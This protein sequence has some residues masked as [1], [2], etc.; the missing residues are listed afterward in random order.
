MHN[1]IYEVM[2]TL[3]P[4]QEEDKDLVKKRVLRILSDSGTHVGSSEVSAIVCKKKSV[5]ARRKDVKYHV[6]Y[7]VYVG[8]TPSDNF[9][10]AWVQ[11]DEKKQVLII[12]AGPA[13]LFAAL[14]LLEK[15]IQPIILERGQ[16]SELRKADITEINK[17]G[18][19]NPNSNFCF[20]EGGAGTF[21]DGKLYSRSSKRGDISLVLSI[22]HH[23]GADK[24]ILSD[25]HPH[26]GTDNLPAIISN[27]TK[28]IRSFGGIIH[29]NTKCTDFIFDENHH[30]CEVKALQTLT[31]EALSFKCDTVLLATGHSADDIYRLVAKA[32]VDHANVKSDN[33]LYVLQQALEAKTFAMGVRVEHPRETIDRIQYSDSSP[34]APLPSAEYRLTTQIAGRGVYSFCMCPGGYIVPSSSA[35]S[36]IVINGMSAS[37]RNSPWSNAAFVV[38]TRPEDVP[39]DFGNDVLAGL[40]FRSNVEEMAAK[41]SASGKQKNQQAAPAQKLTDFLE[42][43]LSK[44]L[45]NSSYAPGIVSSRLDLWLPEHISL[46]LQEAFHEFDK[47][48]KGFICEEAL[49][50]AP[51]TRTST[52]IRILRNTTTCE[53]PVL[54]G[55]YPAG[56]GAGYSGGIVSSAMDGE[57]VAKAIIQHKFEEEQHGETN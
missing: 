30:I 54:K 26:I 1:M 10:P 6:R 55:V 25:A 45:P 16:E 17:T 4:G 48:M 32:A 40:N 33:V 44:N 53:N 5:D 42:G 50:I 37:K 49:L 23:H 8:E 3:F 38:E 52:P 18:N 27:I 36:H 29:F 20:G 57:N 12:G 51:E 9:I 19:V 39:S 31:N 7:A 24:S 2:L 41:E 21:S 14:T 22:L 13:G 35:P 28:T 43:R 34:E 15:G 56:E 11:A 47:K 46:R